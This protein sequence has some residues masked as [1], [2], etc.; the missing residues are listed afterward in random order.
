M[1]WARRFVS[2]LVEAGVRDLVLCPGSRSTPLAVAALETEGLRVHAVVDERV[3]GFFALGQARASGTASAVVC[4]SGTAAA[5]LYPAV[6]EAS[7]ACVPLLVVT[8]DRPWE[9]GG[10]MASQTIDQTRFFGGFV[11]AA[12]EL[13]LPDGAP[14][15]QRA[16]SRCALQAVTATRWPTPGPVHVNA[17]FRKP[18]EPLAGGEEHAG[19]VATHPR[20]P[21]AGVGVARVAL[22]APGAG[23]GDALDA[24]ASALAASAAGLLI[25]GPTPVGGG[26]ALR[27]ALERLARAS[28]LPLLAEATSQARF[29]LDAAGITVCPSFDSV[30]RA[31]VFRDQAPDLVVSFG[32]P[33]TSA[34][35][36]AL[37]ER[38]PTLPRWVVAP[39]AWN[40]PH[41]SATALLW[42][43][44]AAAA[45]ALALRLEAGAPGRQHRAGGGAGEPGHRV[46]DDTAMPPPV[47]ARARWCAGLARAER[48]VAA[49]VAAELAEATLTEG[50]VTRALRDA[51]PAGALLA[52]GNSLPV[53]HLDAYCPHDARALGVLHQRGAAGIDGLI[54]GA[55]G[56]RSV[57]DAPVALLLGD[58]STQHDLGGLAVAA[59]V[60]GP[61]PVVVIDNRGGR[62]FDQLP[63]ADR[64]PRAVMERAFAMP[65]ALDLSAAVR[66]FGLPFARVRT[67][68]ELVAALAQAFA[69]ERA[70]VIEAVVD[71]ADARLRARRLHAAV[72]DTQANP[73]GAPVDADATGAPVDADATGAPVDADA[74]GAPVD[75][76]ATGAP[77]DAE[78]T[79]IFVDDTKTGFPVGDQSGA[80]RRLATTENQR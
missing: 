12:M 50:Q 10:V 8:A 33:P 23:D 75:A 38:H 9:L 54:S 44:P 59:A 79:G 30:L 76:D 40:D 18:L 73:T 43:D 60:P 58:L 39:H 35:W 13:G 34:S 17:R 46:E 20:H 62:I 32:A 64:V 51:C 80:R 7:M 56:A 4:T 71:P 25:C 72:D 28:G 69:A 77:V 78:S 57:S 49:V 41:S 26:P 63:V 74:T 36:A 31:R 61:L 53:R 15:A 68:A 11:R 3:A 22:P 47:A 16:A 45:L 37:L 55:A 14:L 21:A 70:M 24:L 67:R 42:A 27:T 5:H 6:V 66:A 2:A 52:I 48:A 19:S 1:A 29:G 65:Q